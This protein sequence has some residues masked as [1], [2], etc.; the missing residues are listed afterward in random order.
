M[1]TKNQDTS[2]EKDDKA[3]VTLPGTVEKIIP[4]DHDGSEKHKS[5]WKEPSI[6]I[7]KFALTIPLRAQ[8]AKRSV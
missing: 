7:A 8:L 4:T 6:C 2:D 3:S 5:Q 1:S